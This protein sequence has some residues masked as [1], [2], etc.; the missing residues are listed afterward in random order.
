[1]HI[2][3]GSTTLTQAEMG[4]ARGYLGA[5]EQ[6]HV[7]ICSRLTKN[8]TKNGNCGPIESP[9]R[10]VFHAGV[11]EPNWVLFLKGP[12]ITNAPSSLKR[13]LHG[14][15]NLARSLWFCPHSV[16][17]SRPHGEIRQ[18]ATRTRQHNLT[19]QGLP[20]PDVQGCP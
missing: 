13:C 18:V 19:S 6:L 16:V 4:L 2:A 11:A 5:R 9:L 14:L 8:Q 20:P 12:L 17:G 3:G 10:E 7:P 15:T 1:V